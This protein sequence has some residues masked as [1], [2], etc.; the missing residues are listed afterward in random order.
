MP[1]FDQTSSDLPTTDKDGNAVTDTNPLTLADV[2]VRQLERTD[3]ALGIPASGILNSPADS[4]HNWA[5]LGLYLR[6]IFLAQEIQSII[7]AEIVIE[8]ASLDEAGIAELANQ[9]EG[10]G[11]TDNTRIMTSAQ[12]LDALRSGSPFAANT[13]R[14]G[15][16]QRATQS[17]VSARAEATKFVTPATL[18]EP[19]SVPNATQ[20]TRGIA[21]LAN[22]TEGRGGT[23]DD[24]IM[25]S[26]QV[27]DALRSGSPFGANT[28]RKG[29]VQRATQSE[30]SARTESTKYVTPATLPSPSS[31]PDAT[32]TTEGI[33]EIANQNEGRGGTDNSRIMTAK[34][35]LDFLRNGT[36][37][38]ATTSRR[39]TAEVAT[40]SE[41]DSRSGNSK[42]VTPSTL[43][44]ASAV[45]NASTTVRGIAELATQSEVDARSDNSKIVTPSTL[46]EPSSVPNASTSTRGIAEIATQ[47][48][49]DAGVDNSKIV[50][51]AT[52]PEPSAVP[53]AST[54]T[55]GI[56]ELANQT[57]GRGGTDTG[58]IMT[59]QRV[60]DQI[61]DGTGA[62]ANTTRRGTIEIASTGEADAGNDTSRAMT[63]ALV[64]RLIDAIPDPPN[65]STGT[66]GLIEQ[67][68]Q[69]EADAGNDTSRSMTPA[70]VKRR[71]DAK[72]VELTQAQ[73]DALTPNSNVLY[74]IVG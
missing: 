68:N 13:T 53:N 12:V 49:V 65:S 32:E 46:P 66:R 18:P 40:Q 58:R 61:R 69:S 42:F 1:D 15:T 5:L 22:Q 47:S 34:R 3:P 70:L 51:P 62:S 63:A 21:E 29:T 60:L 24:R 50:T 72:I 41:V 71:I 54:G 38:S 30:V 35:V 57:E 20:S 28:A 52:L 56:A 43:P 27:L 7:D 55:R 11:G 6:D 25:T 17:E 59:S 14:K 9:A 31:V 26:E 2:I 44:E 4:P 19:S 73:F 45:P 67:A 23:D 64:T 36:G 37:A 39:G 74:V 8:G 48:E 33:A 16:A 10:R